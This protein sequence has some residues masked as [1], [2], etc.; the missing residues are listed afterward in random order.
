MIVYFILALSA[1]SITLDVLILRGIARRYPA[2]P[3]MKRA[4]LIHFLLLDAAIVAGLLLYGRFSESESQRMMHV[5]LWVIWLFF[6]TILP[7][8]TYGLISLL[9]YPARWIRGR[10]VAFFTKAGLAAAVLVLAGLVWGATGG[11]NRIVVDELTLVSDRLPAA[12]DDYKIVF[13]TDLHLGNLPSNN[14][15]VRRMVE[16]INRQH[17]D[18]VVN[19]G[20][21][22][23]IDSR[24]LNGEVMAL[25][26]GIRSRDGVYSVL[27]NHDLGFYMRP[28]ESFTPRESVDDLLARQRAMGWTPLVNESAFIGRDRDSIYITG[29]NFPADAS[30]RGRDTGTAGCNMKGVYFNLSPYRY[31]LLVAHTPDQWDKALA[32]GNPDLTLSGHTHAMQLKFRIGKWQWSPAEWM[33]KRWSGLYTK[34]KHHLFVND[35][36]GYVM[37]PMRIGTPPSITVITLKAKAVK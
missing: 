35:G 2:K 5:I 11:R 9:N 6:A 24:E 26:S 4:Y 28:K 22:V 36:M 25:L 8:A 13:F 37:F 7:K 14:R 1:I 21:L 15:L 29:V 10:N 27:G 18:L 32:E 33:Y 17:P 20:D 12:F 19:G 34:G 3:W 31:N 30:H 23:N 16:K